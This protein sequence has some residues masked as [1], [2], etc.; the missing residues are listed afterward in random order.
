MTSD[1]AMERMIAALDRAEASAGALSYAQAAEAYV[2]IANQWEAVA[3]RLA[4]VEAKAA[5]EHS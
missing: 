5:R 4:D 1:E 3:W 2:K